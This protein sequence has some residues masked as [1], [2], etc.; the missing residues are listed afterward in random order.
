MKAKYTPNAARKMAQCHANEVEL[1]NKYLRACRNA[2]DKQG[3]KDFT[4]L[5]REHAAAW[6][7]YTK[8]TT[9]GYRHNLEAGAELVY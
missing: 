9:C 6:L 2:G 5:V 7:R 1:C 8:M 3:V 4:R